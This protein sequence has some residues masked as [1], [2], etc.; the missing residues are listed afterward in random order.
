MFNQLRDM[1]QADV[2]YADATDGIGV[3]LSD[4]AMFQRAA[5]A[6][7]T[8]VADQADDPLRATAREVDM[9]TGFY[10]LTLPLLKHGIP[11][12]PVQLDNL[13]RSPG[14]LDRYRVLVLSYEFMKPLQAGIHLA[15]AAWVQRGGTLIYVGADTDPFHQARDWWNQ[16]LADYASPERTLV[17]NAGPRASTCCWRIRMWHGARDR[18]A[19]PIPPLSRDPQKTPTDCAAW[20]DSGTEVAQGTCVTRNYVK[21]RRGPYVI[22]AV[23]DESISDEPLRL[24]GHFVDLLDPQLTVHDEVAWRPVSKRGCWTW[25]ASAA[26]ARYCW[27]QPAASKRGR[28]RQRI[29]NT[30]SPRQKACS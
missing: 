16:G 17:R 21:L 11:I 12:R 22:A 30:R 18:G 14:Y 8:G 19:C 1:Q 29:S 23:F 27:P 10:G 9:L 5:P 2:D 24:A 15:L 20:C 13:V 4:S 25:T 28:Q 26:R 6:T 3:F 7:S